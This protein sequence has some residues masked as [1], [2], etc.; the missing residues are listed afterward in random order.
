[1]L[2]K[3]E[4]ITLGLRLAVVVHKR[5]VYHERIFNAIANCQTRAKFI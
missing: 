4:G 5:C 3:G 1:M 2:T